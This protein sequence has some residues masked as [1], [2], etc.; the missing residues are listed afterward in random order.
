MSRPTL[1]ADAARRL[2]WPLRL[3]ATGMA[4]ERLWRAFWPLATVLL[5]ALAL[6]GSGAL[7][8][9]IPPFWVAMAAGAVALAA[10][11]R[12]VRRF[13]W[14]T[15][16][17]VLARIDAALPGQP[18][19]ALLDQQ[20]IGRADAGSQAIW[21]AH[22][23]RM[24]ARL[25]GARAVEPDLR[26]ARADPYALRFVVLI[27]AIMVAGFGSLSRVVDVT[28]PTGPAAQAA[29]TASW[30]GWIEPPA[31]TG[32]P[33]LYLND[34]PA[35][36]LAVPTGSRVTLR[37]YGQQGVLGLT[38]DVAEAPIEAGLPFE[39]TR[40]GQ[41]EVTGPGGR[42][43]RITAIGDVP[44]AVRPGGP[45][46][47]A[48]DGTMS[49]AF[50][51]TDDYGVVAGRAEFTLD[52][53]ALDRRHGLA[54]DPEP[55]DPIVVDLP[56]PF[57]GDRALIEEV[58]HENFMQHPWAEMP[59]T[60][61]LIVEDAAGQVAQSQVH[62]I[63]LPGRRFLTPLA[64][65]LIEQRRDLL[66]TRANG[67][68]VAQ[69]LRAVAHNADEDLFP[70]AGPYLKLGLAIREL[71]SAL[72]PELT[73]EARDRMARVLWDMAVAI[74][75][76]SLGDA[77][78]RL[79]RA[80]ER[81]AEAMRQGASPEELAELM[82]E[83]REAMR[84][85]MNQLAQQAPQGEQ[86]PM[87][88]NMMTMT[89]QDLADMMAEIEEL[90]R[91]GRMDEAMAALEMLRQLMENMQATQGQ[92]GQG[93]SPGEQ[94]MQGLQETLRDQQG[95][96]DEAFRD[97][98]EQGGASSSAGE[99]SDNEGRDGGQGRG[100]AHSGEGGEGEGSDGEDG[101]QGDLA[102][103]QG[104]LRDQ[105]EAQ[106][107]GLPGA[108]TEEGQ[109]ARDAL[110][111]AGDAMDGAEEALRE[112]E[113]N[114]A[115]D[116]QAEAMEAMREGMRNL[117][118]A[119]RREQAARQGQQGTAAGEPGARRNDPL[120]RE[121]GAGGMTA[122]QGPLA[123]GEDVYRRAQELM[124][125]IRRRSGEGDRPELELDYLKRLLDQ[126]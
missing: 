39:I 105:L 113:F 118:D 14:P 110:G 92:P 45:M 96:S 61:Q 77:L 34:Q 82:D 81:L 42:R 101:Q 90:M 83:L 4:V 27:A 23:A 104:Q 37:L 29:L 119:M 100:Q 46:E 58:L 65:V 49:Q 48:L 64:Q 115:L 69:V 41:I 25:S 98:Q 47:R 57:R 91:Q 35:G 30:E 103:R 62:E 28:L 125:D 76:G 75:E 8:A 95:L 38:Q 85:Y 40:N 51:A 1:P 24:E 10:F 70:G 73:G 116:R 11:A 3:T 33:S 111:R 71:E 18:I 53:G 67:P 60:M 112:G 31:Y 43:W 44:P 126:F 80:Q 102:G 32:K 13:A 26:V 123:D 108:G 106:R 9:L 63:L 87:G 55:R 7:N 66:W 93:Q 54:A 78:A 12:G 97:L 72:A 74:E 22:Q 2:A 52:A 68:R 117:E 107:R 88:D 20:A 36:P 50:V 6:L 122:D 94:A 19:A 109:A 56:M 5:G 59:V 86:P 124:E 89:P 21:A 99:S 17:E 79:Q 114:E 84:D 120:G 15:R 121:A 16:P